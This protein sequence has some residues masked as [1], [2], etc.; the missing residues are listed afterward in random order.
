MSYLVIYTCMLAVRIDYL[1]CGITSNGEE[2]ANFSAIDICKY[3]IS[4]GGYSSSS[5]C[6][7]WAA[8]F[9]CGTPRAFN[10]LFCQMIKR[11]SFGMI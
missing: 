7:G 5:W 2:R 11:H 10:I 6:L 9:Y 3:A 4:V 8:L 1:K